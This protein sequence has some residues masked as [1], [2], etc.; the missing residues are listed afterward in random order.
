M[1][2]LTHDQ[3]VTELRRRLTQ[4]DATVAGAAI[5]RAIRWVNRQGSFTFQLTGAAPITVNNTLA[6]PVDPEAAGVR[7]AAP[8]D[9]DMG[10]AHFIRQESTGLPVRK[11]GIQDL[12]LDNAMGV[13]A[14]VAGAIVSSYAIQGRNFYFRPFPS[15]A[16]DLTIQYHKTTTDISGTQTSNLPKEF[17]DLVID[18]A[19]AEE[20]RIYDVGEVW[21]T[22][23]ARCQDQIR[24]LLDSYRS[25]SFQEM[26]SSDAKVAAEEKSAIGQA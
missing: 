9:M 15:G 3:M 20:R 8:A 12:W 24:V 6:G 18:L 22:L 16:L 10:K 5:N 23:L 4:L 21:V 19:E 14:G 2:D 13:P 17:D 7:Q 26:S 11:V 25:V 1:G